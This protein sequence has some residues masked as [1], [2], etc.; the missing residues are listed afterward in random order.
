LKFDVRLLEID[1]KLFNELD[2]GAFKHKID[3]GL[4]N[5]KTAYQIVLKIV[6]ELSNIDIF[7]WPHYQ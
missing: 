7:R 6:A 2:L 4:E 5:R 1:Q 3:N